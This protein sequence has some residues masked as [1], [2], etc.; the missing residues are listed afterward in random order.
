MANPNTPYGLRPYAYRSGA[1]YNGAVRTYYVPAA[2]A[3]AL[4]IGDPVAILVNSSDGNGIPTAEIATAGAGAT[5]FVLGCYQ[6]RSNNAGA[7]T[8]TVTQDEAG[9]LAAATEAFLHGC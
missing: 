7:R 5:H 6:G 8:I 1:P 3:T 4:Y 2:N 9:Y